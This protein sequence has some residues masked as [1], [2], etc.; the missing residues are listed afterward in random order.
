MLHPG[1]EQRLVVRHLL[2]VFQH[3]LGVY[4]HQRAHD[5]GVNQRAAQRQIAALRHAHQHRFFHTQ[6]F[7]QGRQIVGRVIVAERFAML[8]ICRLPV[9]TL[10]PADAAILPLQSLY[11]RLEHGVIHEQAVREHN[12]RATPSR[13]LVVDILTIDLGKRHAGL[14]LQM[15]E[16]PGELP[17]LST[18]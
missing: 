2:G 6:I 9:T 12:G 15:V 17:Q 14:L 10:V 3:G 18:S 1:L 4:Q 11:L 13:V 8:G 7:E 5:I 16:T